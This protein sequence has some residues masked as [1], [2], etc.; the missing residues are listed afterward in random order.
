MRNIISYLKI[1]EF[2]TNMDVI[3]LNDQML[4]YVLEVFKN[5]S[6]ISWSLGGTYV[7]KWVSDGQEKKGPRRGLF[8]KS[9]SGYIP[10]LDSA[11]KWTSMMQII[12]TLLLLPKEVSEFSIFSFNKVKSLRHWTKKYKSNTMSV[13]IPFYQSNHT[14]VL[15]TITIV[16]IKIPYSV[17]MVVPPFGASTKTIWCV[18]SE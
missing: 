18:P 1:G 13:T 17:S 3:C 10:S 7:T 2:C 14:K 6:D 9:I 15:K 4:F 8:F 16:D 5:S 12:L 11:W